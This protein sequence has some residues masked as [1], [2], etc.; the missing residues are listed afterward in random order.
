VIANF[1]A[2]SGFLQA[3]SIQADGRTTDRQFSTA[4]LANYRTQLD[5]L[6]A[7]IN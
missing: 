6:I 2:A 3:Q 5:A 7:A 1:P 4:Q